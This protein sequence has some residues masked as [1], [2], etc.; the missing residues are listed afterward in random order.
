MTSD[1]EAAPLIALETRRC[2]AIGSGDLEALDDVLSDDYVHVLAPGKVVNK[3][4]Y[5]EMIRNGPRK[6]E[7]EALHVRLYGQAAVITGTLVNHIGAPGDVRRVIP[8]YCTQVALQEDGK[9]RFVSYIL[10][11]KRDA[12]TAARP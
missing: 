9:W 1:L 11:Q 4:E 3:A 6:P 12:P 7:R 8:A 10:T 2:E 5:I